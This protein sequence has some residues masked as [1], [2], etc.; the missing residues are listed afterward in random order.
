MIFSRSSKLSIQNA[1]P[2]VAS[3]VEFLYSSKQFYQE[4]LNLINTA[5]KRIYLTALYLQDDEAGRAVLHAIY[6][7]KQQNPELDVCIFVDY[8]RAQR[9]LIGAEK[10]LGNRQF[11]I[12]LSEQYEHDINIYGVAVKHKE[13][14]GVLHLKGFIFD[15]TLLFSGASINNVYMHVEDKYRC[16]RFHKFSSANLADSFVDYLDKYFISSECAPRINQLAVPEKKQLK[17]LINKLKLSLRKSS[18]QVKSSTTANSDLLVTPLVG[19]G[20]RGNQLNLSARKV[21][22]AANKKL[23]VFTPYF[24]FPKALAVDLRRALKKGVDVTIVVGDKKANDFYVADPDKFSTIGIVPYIYEKLLRRFIKLNQ[25]FI[26]KGQLNVHL[27]RDGQNSYHLKGVVADDT[28]HL[29]TGSNLNPRAWSLDLEN[30]LL[31][32]DRK[33]QLAQAW[34]QELA[35]ILE[36][37][38]RVESLDCLESVADYPEKPRELLRK[39]K[40]T[41]FD[42]ILKR[43][44]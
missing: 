22:K 31:V 4:L 7:A 13:F 3:D 16:D 44:L 8:H 25:S 40:L 33:Q 34:H 36:N 20:A 27:W 2:L 30:G 10:S 5:K 37:T 21:F 15:N 24:N 41:Q 18:Y 26:D 32:C 29:I 28:Y 9:G 14:L 1:I 38:K 17:V 42:R 6:A 39:I 35:I 19:L 11:Y 12:D 23:V 43:F